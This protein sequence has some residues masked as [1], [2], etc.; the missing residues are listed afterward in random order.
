MPDLQGFFGANEL[1][2]IDVTS[3]SFGAAQAGC[4]IIM[5]QMSSEA[6]GA[7]L[8]RWDDRGVRCLSSRVRMWLD[9]T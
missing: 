4:G 5:F 8:H 1:F 7:T 9:A 6:G 2:V 3:V